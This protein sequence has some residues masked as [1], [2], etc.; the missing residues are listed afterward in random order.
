MGTPAIVQADR[1]NGSCT[2]HQVPSP[3]SGAP[4]PA[5][6]MPFSS[7]LL[8]GL[9][10]NV[11]IGGKAAATLGSS[12]TNT[13]AHVGLH[14]SDPYAV[15]SMQTGRVVGGSAAVLI[16]GQPAA[17]ASAQATC[18]ATPGTLVPGIANVLIG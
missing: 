9:S 10:A 15:A 14:A 17:T 2:I 8:Q 7:P 13:P 5:P 18:C 4:Q 6:P 16:G 12:G 1:I 3:S 11:R